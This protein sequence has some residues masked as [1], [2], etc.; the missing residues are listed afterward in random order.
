MGEQQLCLCTPWL[1]EKTTDQHSG[2]FPRSCC[3][4]G[5]A[6]A[7]PRAGEGG[8]RGPTVTPKAK[9]PRTP[10]VPQ[11][12]CPPAGQSRDVPRSAGLHQRDARRQFSAVRAG[13]AW[14]GVPRAAPGPPAGL[15]Q[16]GAVEG[17][18]ARAQGALSHPS[19]PKPLCNSTTEPAGRAR[20]HPRGAAAAPAPPL[21]PGAGP[22][23]PAAQPPPETPRAPAVPHPP[24]LG[25]TCP[26]PGEAGGGAG[27]RRPNP[28]RLSPAQ[29][30]PARPAQ[31]PPLPGPPGPS[32]SYLAG[33]G[34]TPRPAAADW[35]SAPHVT[36]RAALPRCVSPSD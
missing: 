11:P 31:P 21:L 7:E 3:C 36:R 8:Q 23:H 26:C 16:P 18:A 4:P 24:Q 35:L 20:A 29:P 10:R 17:V 5:R 13:R 19:P 25:P 33:A 14:L 32:R 28:R 34:A 9:E 2:L 30:G 15:E 22:A 27:R 6:E 1:R 12:Q